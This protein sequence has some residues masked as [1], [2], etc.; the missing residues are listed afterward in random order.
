MRHMHSLAISIC[1][2]LRIR[3]DRVAVHRACRRIAEACAEGAAGVAGA[4][5]DEE[6]TRVRGGLVYACRRCSRRSLASWDAAEVEHV[7]AA[8]S[9]LAQFVRGRNAMDCCF[10]LSCK[11]CRFLMRRARIPSA[12]PAPGNIDFLEGDGFLASPPYETSLL[13]IPLRAF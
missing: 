13:V 8:R 1:K 6:L 7:V 11:S 5:T 2:H 12:P 3:Y 9:L 10:E 4:P